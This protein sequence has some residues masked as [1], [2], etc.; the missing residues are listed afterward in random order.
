MRNA[1]LAAKVVENPHVKP[2]LKSPPPLLSSPPSQKKKLIKQLMELAL[3]SLFIL[4]SVVFLLTLLRNIHDRN[5]HKQCYLIDY[6]CFKLPTDLCGE[7]VRRN[8]LL[9]VP[10][11]R[12][13]L[14]VIVSSGL[15]ENT[16][17][18]RNIIVGDE[19]SPALS[20][21]LTEMD[22]CFDP[23]LDSLFRKT[24]VRPSE[25][26]VLVVNVSMFSPSPSLSSRIIN[27]Y[28]M[29]EDTKVFNLAG[30]GCSASLISLDLVQNLFKCYK[31]KLAVV[32]TSESIAPNWYSGN[33]RSMQPELLVQVGAAAISTLHTVRS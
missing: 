31:N 24:E 5:K 14:K 19:T 7:I 26:D 20:D 11:Y 13:L 22:E 33:H 21:S 1:I 25:V 17:G 23:T 2:H 4:L 30:M 27:R 29:R 9:G 15:G 28:K 32:V 3:L 12:F 18:P 8:K 10:D 16:Y 6:V